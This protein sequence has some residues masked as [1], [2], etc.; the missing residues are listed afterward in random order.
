MTAFY[1][2]FDRAA[3]EETSLQTIEKAFELGVNFL[4]TA[5]VYQVRFFI[6]ILLLL[7]I[8]IQLLIKIIIIIVF[9]SWRWRKLY[10]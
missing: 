8:F 9:W 5:W 10:K 3:H 2:D 7:F 6:F 4:D 1:G